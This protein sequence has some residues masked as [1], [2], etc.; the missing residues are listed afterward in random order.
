MLQLIRF[1]ANEYIKSTEVWNLQEWIGFQ[2]LNS[3]QTAALEEE[4][5]WIP[6]MEWH[7]TNKN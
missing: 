4:N 5:H 3:G 6:K 1:L 7:R 2:A